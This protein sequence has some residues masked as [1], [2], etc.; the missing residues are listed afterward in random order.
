MNNET[1][2]K[3]KGSFAYENWN[4]ALAGAQI[5]STLE[6]PLFTDARI[7]G[8]MPKFHSPYTL[9]NVVPIVEANVPAPAI[10]LRMDYHSEYESGPL[11]KTNIERYHGGGISDEI[12]ALVSL[13]LGVRLKAGGFT[14]YFEPDKDPK[15]RPVSWELDKNPVLLKTLRRVVLPQALGE[16]NLSSA[17]LVDSFKD[18]SPNG[19]IA[20]IRAAKLYQ[21]GLWIV[22]SEPALSWIMLVSAVEAAA[23]YWRPSKEPALERLRLFDPKLEKILMQAGGEELTQKVA[24]RIASFMGSTRKFV[25]FILAFLPEAP[26]NRPPEFYQHSWDVE[27]IS[28]SMVK[29]YKWR[30]YALHRGIPFPVPMC[31]PPGHLAGCFEEVPVG[32]A[33]GARGAVWTREDA[34]MLFHTF[35]Y[36]VRGSL[37]RWWQSMIDSVAPDI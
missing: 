31:E 23:N 11:A 35:E 36:I 3:D 12:A 34:P 26:P 33:T 32:L 22:E 14:R 5:K 6:Y 27:E 30:S 25:D 18:I 37:T 8:E 10:V 7:I 29:I 13:C 2:G 21:D 24:T 15:G 1:D 19:S 4:L 16:H 28:K 17:A 20:L 9:L